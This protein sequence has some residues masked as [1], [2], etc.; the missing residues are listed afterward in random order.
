MMA[1][2]SNKPEEFT[3]KILKGLGVESSF[4]MIL[5]GDSLSVM[6]PDP[7]PILHIL[8]TLRVAPAK[9]L[10]IGDSPG[11]IEAGRAAGS[12]TCAV[13]YGYRTKAVL[14]GAKPDFMIDDIR[15]LVHLF[16]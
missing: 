15:E 1:V 8:R 16:D 9:S 6:K 13:S 5:G 4:Q 12:L 7:E 2:A 3:R 14:Q 10:M 11:D